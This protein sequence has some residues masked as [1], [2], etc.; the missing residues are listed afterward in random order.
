MDEIDYKLNSRNASLIS[1]VNII[2]ITEI[3]FTHLIF[4]FIH[5]FIHLYIYIY[6]ITLNLYYIFI[7]NIQANRNN[8]EKVGRE[9]RYFKSKYS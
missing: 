6:I 9:E 3:R 8:K 1:H 5:V 7:G 4:V 2:K